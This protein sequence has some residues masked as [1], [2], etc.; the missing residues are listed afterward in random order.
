MIALMGWYV[1]APLACLVL[2]VAT[3]RY[4]SLGS[5]VTSLL[6]A[7]L[8]ASVPSLRPYWPLGLAGAVIVFWTHRANIERLLSGTEN[9]LGRTAPASEPGAQPSEEQVPPQQ[10]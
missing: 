6:I 1:L 7:A 10:G 5:L 8:M 4:V 9:R 3:S 2:I